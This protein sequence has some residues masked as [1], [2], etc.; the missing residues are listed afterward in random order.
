MTS[1]RPKNLLHT[2]RFWVSIARTTVF[3][4]LALGLLFVLAGSLSCGDDD[5]AHVSAYVVAAPSL[6]YRAGGAEVGSLS[7]WCWKDAVDSKKES[8]RPAGFLRSQGQVQLAGWPSRGAMKGIS[9]GKA[10]DGRRTSAI[11]RMA[12]SNIE[13]YESSGRGSSEEKLEL[14]AEVCCTCHHMNLCFLAYAADCTGLTRLIRKYKV[15]KGHGCATPLNQAYCTCVRADV[16]A[17]T[18]MNVC[19]ALP[20]LSLKPYVPGCKSEGLTVES[21]QRQINDSDS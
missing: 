20:L 17:R 8:C 12:G 10:M 2:A 1:G 18:G 13:D 6:Y 7:Q 5:T 4:Q 14:A 15:P 19:A 21:V 3:S 9:R 16:H 11:V